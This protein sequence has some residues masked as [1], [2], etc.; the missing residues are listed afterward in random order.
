MGMN[1]GN[2]SYLA[3]RMA[4]FIIVSFFVLQSILNVDIKGIIY[5][6]GLLMVCTI[7]TYMNGIVSSMVD[8][9]KP[10]DPLPNAKCSII[11]LGESGGYLSKIPLSLTVYSFTFFYLLIFVMNTASTNAKGVLDSKSLSSQSIN[12]A[13]QQNIPLFIIFPVLIILESVWLLT[14]NCVQNILIRGGISIILGG[15]GGVIWALII[16]SVGNPSLQYLSKSGVDVCNRPSKS[17]YKCKK[18]TTI[19]TV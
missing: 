8:D 17:L 5:L 9:T 4:P 1:I 6:A 7:I 16:S 10:D 11:T 19:G 13:L 15:V 14:N 18:N 2:V 3:F 12:T